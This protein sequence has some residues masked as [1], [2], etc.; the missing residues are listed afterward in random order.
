MNQDSSVPELAGL[1]LAAGGSRR[2]KQPKQL[3]I[4]EGLPLVRRAA[5]AAAAVCTAGVTVVTGSERS[6]VEAAL[7]GSGVHT[8]HNEHWREG[9]GTSLAK[10]ADW[11]A[12]GAIAGDFSGVMVLLCDQ[13]DIAVGQLE[14]LE[15]L[16]QNAPSLPAAAVF[17]G[18]VGAP[19]VF[20][21]S[22]LERLSVLQ[23]DQGAR[24][25]LRTCNDLQ[26]LDMP[27]AVRD[28]DTPDD[29]S[30]L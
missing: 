25:L 20:P 7:D 15:R 12:G 23:G 26:V 27:E 17:E 3:V 6:K 28:I 16:W 18:R 4:H 22:W 5:E 19:A 10:G 24:A 9:M 13:P 2:L 1:L 21:V 30:S 14:A 8:V 29:L 11:L